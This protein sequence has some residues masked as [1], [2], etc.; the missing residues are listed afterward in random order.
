MRPITAVISDSA[1]GGPKPSELSQHD[2]PY[3]WRH[4]QPCCLV[5]SLFS[6]LLL[7]TLSPVLARVVVNSKNLAV[8]ILLLCQQKKP[9]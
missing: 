1:M 5:F 4:I 2:Y 9:N 8:A 7:I 3:V 6:L